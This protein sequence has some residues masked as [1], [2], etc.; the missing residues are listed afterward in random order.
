[1]EKAEY[2]DGLRN[3]IT[4]SYRENGNLHIRSSYTNDNLD[5]LYEVFH[6]NGRKAQKGTYKNG[7]I[8]GPYYEYT[9]ELVSKKTIFKK[10]SKKVVLSINI[11]PLKMKMIISD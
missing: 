4:E 1:M 10:E 6:R 9:N 8:D 5:G 3:G 2:K 11:I 7:L